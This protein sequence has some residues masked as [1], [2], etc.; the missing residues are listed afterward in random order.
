[1]SGIFGKAKDYVW[2]LINAP[3]TEP[4]DDGSD[5]GW[6]EG[7]IREERAAY[8]DTYESEPRYEEETRVPQKRTASAR[9]AQNNKVLE[10][11]SKGAGGS[12]VV[13]RHPLDVSEAAKVCDLVR[14]DKVCVVDLTGMERG[15]AQRIA[16]FLGGAC[17]AI[18]GCIQRISKDIFIIAPEGVRISGDVRDELEKD[19]YV[20]PKASGRR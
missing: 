3:N 2:S 15:M 9:Q 5:D 4:I 14:E 18:N 11:Y 20:I 1:M 17:Y 12:E 10:M 8:R 16:D 13:I 7:E 19:G 6:Y